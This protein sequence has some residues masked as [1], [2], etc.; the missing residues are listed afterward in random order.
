MQN[1]K[2][3]GAWRLLNPQYLQKKVDAYG[4][5]FSWKSHVVLLFAALAGIG[6][7]G[8]L[9]RLETR[10]LIVVMAAVAGMLPVL[11]LDMYKGMYERRRFADVTAY[12]EQ[13]LYAFQKE[14]KVVTALKEC[15]ENFAAGQM[16]SAIEM[17]IAHLEGGM[18]SSEAGVLRESLAMI[19]AD[20]PCEKLAMVH[21]LLVGAEELG[22]DMTDAIL[23]SLEDLE[24]F[25]KRGYRLQT[26][27]KNCHTDNIISIVVAVLLCMIAL[28]VLDGMGMMFAGAREVSVFAIPAIQLS[29]VLFLLA[30]LGVFVKSTKSLTDN[31]LQTAGVAED[32]YLEKCYQKVI[33][34]R[35]RFGSRIARRDVTK[36]L[37]L[38]LPQWLMELALLLQNNNVQVALA[39]SA[40]GTPVVLR[41]ELTG[42]TERISRAP[43]RLDSYTGFCEEFDIPEA[44]SCMK[45]L[46]AFSENGS[47]NMQMQIGRLVDRVGQMQQVSEEMINEN[48]AF[49]MKLIFSYPVVAATA[50]LLV[51]LSVGMVVMLQMLG[52]IGGV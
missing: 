9:F 49:R 41:E 47:G 8:F 30:L 13:M 32:A 50:K 16:R 23:F 18:P 31:W 4:Y 48:I 22:G 24:G 7:V 29:S 2:K 6:A 19:E 3:Y 51:D 1:R 38:C 12:M 5:H 26:Q 20:Y 21:R 37:Y 52:A 10:G 25:K 39:R 28:Y 35:R 46:Y 27:K 33:S 43:E 42:L 45:M 14:G 17:A 34:G 40:E 44:A 15:R 36:H 11:I